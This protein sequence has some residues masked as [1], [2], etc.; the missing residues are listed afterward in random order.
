MCDEHDV[1]A[2]VGQLS[3]FAANAANDRCQ[4]FHDIRVPRSVRP[5]SAVKGFVEQITNFH[6]VQSLGFERRSINFVAY[7]LSKVGA[8]PAPLNKS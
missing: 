7:N 3:P 1:G 4:L 2:A 5:N 6:K 8:S